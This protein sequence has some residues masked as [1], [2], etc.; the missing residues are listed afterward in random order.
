MTSSGAVRAI[1]FWRWRDYDL[2]W[3]RERTSQ[4]ID[5]GCSNVSCA[6]SASTIIGWFSQAIDLEVHTHK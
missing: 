3:C 4:R 6:M 1:I 5:D 2:D